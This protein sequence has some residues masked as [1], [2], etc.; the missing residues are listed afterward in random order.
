MFYYYCYV[1]IKQKL[2]D[3][4]VMKKLICLI[5]ALVLLYI[6]LTASASVNVYSDSKSEY[7]V[8]GEDVLLYRLILP[9]NYDAKNTYPLILFLHGAGE[10][11]SDNTKQLNNCVQNIANSAPNAIIVAPQCSDGNQ[12]VDT[13]WSNS[14]YS[15]D[16]VA[17][18]NELQMVMLLLDK[19]KKEYSVDTDRIYAS[20]ISMGGFG[21]WDLITRHPNTFAAAIPVCG[22][23]D[24]SKA[25]LVK[26]I[27]IYTFHGENDWDVPVAGTR[28][29]VEAIKSAGGKKITYT[30][31]PGMGHNIWDDAF[32]TTGLF[33]DLFKHKLS[34]RVVEEVSSE[35]SSD[36]ISSEISSVTPSSTNDASTSSVDTSS[37]SENAYESDFSIYII[38]AVILVIIAA[39][40]TV[41]I[42][43]KRKKN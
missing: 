2:K 34:D 42:V 5:L 16:D 19:L 14:I 27:P 22:G 37:N 7:F 31:Y 23:A 15:T 18:S 36:V 13:P 3:G 25:E 26:D 10:R 28:A 43:V 41:I 9:E 35:T 1:T 38:I 32:A 29:M 24:P 11:G 33:D 30:E 20:G 6:P 17:E 40:I 21:T 39:A 4:A 12:W 8:N